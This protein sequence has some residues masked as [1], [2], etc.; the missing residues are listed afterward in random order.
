MSASQDH[1]FSDLA[2][3]YALGALDAD[4]LRDFE[5][6]MQ[7]CADCRLEVDEYRAVSSLL[8]YAVPSQEP[9]PALR[10]SILAKAKNSRTSPAPSPEGPPGWLSAWRLGPATALLAAASLVLAA[11]ATTGYLRERA[12]HLQTEAAL[13]ASLDELAQR[14][15]VLG[16][17]LAESVSAARLTSAGAN[18]SIRLFWNRDQNVVLVAAFNL[19]PAEAGRT[20]QLWGIP[21][22]QSPVSLGTF[23]T[24]TD[25]EATVLLTV[26]PGVNVQDS[27]LS[28]VTD[29]PAGGSLQ[30]TTTPFLVG[31]WEHA[32]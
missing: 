10:A 7:D 4:E 22:G 20:Y 28:A 2:A 13:A 19:P 6:H 11:V 18:P 32:Q 30:P 24:G 5:A 14:N 3:S 15:A 21:E 9:P 25:G 29:E 12:A 17:F 1:R 16:A 8:A 23:N 31:P 26:P 27:N